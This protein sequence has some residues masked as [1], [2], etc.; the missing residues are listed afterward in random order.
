MIPSLLF[1]DLVF[2]PLR[3]VA[4][5][6][7]EVRHGLRASDTGFAGFGEVYFTEILPGAI[8]GWRRHN[9]ATLNLVVVSG[10]VRFVVHDGAGSW[11]AA[12]VISAEDAAPYGRLTVPPGLWMAVQGVGRSHNLLMNLAS[13]A[14]DATEAEYC[15]L[16]VFADALAA[17]TRDAPPAARDAP[18]TAR[19]VP[20]PA[21]DAYV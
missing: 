6:K 21:P 20:A 13:H 1:S 11:W 7:G 19:Y 4:T 15:E 2:T 5:A 16:A 3:R 9:R 14:H 10:T 17:T 8:K 12:Y 18:T